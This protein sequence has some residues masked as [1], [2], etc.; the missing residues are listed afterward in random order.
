MRARADVNFDTEGALKEHP[1]RRGLAV[2]R[3]LPEGASEGTDLQGVA[4]LFIRP[5]PRC[6]ISAMRNPRAR[7]PPSLAKA[8]FAG[9]GFAAPSFEASI[10]LRGFNRPTLRCTF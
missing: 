8:C 2:V 1:E 4:L 9:I 6:R 7:P 5:L 3:H 10:L